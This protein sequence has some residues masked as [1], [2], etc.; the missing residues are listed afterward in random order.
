MRIDKMR[1]EGKNKR[2][3]RIKIKSNIFYRLNV[4]KLLKT[5]KNNLN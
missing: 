1:L 3:E 4:Q 2:L 5:A